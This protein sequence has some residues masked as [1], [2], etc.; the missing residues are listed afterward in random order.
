MADP[1]PRH[2]LGRKPPAGPRPGRRNPLA[3]LAEAEE[4]GFPIDA[5]G[6]HGI[7]PDAEGRVEIPRWRH[8]IIQFPHPLLEQGLVILD[9]PGL[10]AI[11]AEPELTLN[12]LPNAHAVLFILAADTGVTQSDLAVWR[13]HVNAGR[14]QRGRIVALNKID[15]LWDGL[16]SEADIEREIAGQVAS[17]AATLEIDPAQVYPVSAQKGLVAKVNDDP[18]CSIAAA[19]SARAGAVHRAAAHQARHRARQHLRRRHRHRRPQ[20]RAPQ[21][22]PQRP[23]RAAPGLTDLR[24]KNENVIEYMMRKVRSERRVRAGPAEYYAVRSVFSNLSNNLF[25]HL[26]LDALRDETRAPAR[27]CS[28]RPSPAACAKP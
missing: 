19:S 10:N 13:E 24:G 22:P 21:R 3:S 15:G 1:P 17:V 18:S 6:D 20:P 27:R 5:S 8:A 23:A 14:R 2:Q 9:T 11:G 12:L 4:L 25:G 28:T 7:R 16:R 26:G